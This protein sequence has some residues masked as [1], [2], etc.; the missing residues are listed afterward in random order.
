MTVVQSGDGAPTFAESL[1]F[2]CFTAGVYYVRDIGY[3]FAIVQMHE[4]CDVCRGSGRLSK[5]RGRRVIPYAWK[6]CKACDERGSWPVG[7]PELIGAR[8]RNC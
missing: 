5:R 8:P 3:P 4:V 7:E 6:P 2:A 1:A